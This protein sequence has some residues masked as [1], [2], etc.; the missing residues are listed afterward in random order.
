MKRGR[1]YCDWFIVLFF[2]TGSVMLV[3][4]GAQES[5]N[6]PLHYAAAWERGALSAAV[7]LT[8]IRLLEN[9]K[10]SYPA[11]AQHCVLSGTPRS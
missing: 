3:E 9:P 11:G 5:V 10:F 2:A 7:G 4:A 6:L 1:G 8:A